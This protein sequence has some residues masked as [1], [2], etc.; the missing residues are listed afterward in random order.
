MEYRRMG[1]F[2][3]KI[4]KLALGTM[5]FSNPTDK[6]ESFRIINTTLGDGINIL[7]C[8]NVYAAGES[9]HII[10]EA[11]SENQWKPE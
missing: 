8:V 9:E 11:L 7:D 2:G 5:N 1:R 10:G 6:T 3:L 4:S